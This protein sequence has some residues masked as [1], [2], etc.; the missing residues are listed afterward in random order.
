M[1]VDP[2]TWQGIVIGAVGGAIAG[3]TVPISGWLVSYFRDIR[4]RRAV[5]KWLVNNTEEVAGKQFRSTRTIASYNNL[6]EDRIRFIC[7]SHTEIFL[8]TGP[9]EDLWG[10]FE[11]NPNRKRTF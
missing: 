4:D 9:K 7:S 10:V 5:Y 1:I 2:E 11:K 8:S 6:T 3:L